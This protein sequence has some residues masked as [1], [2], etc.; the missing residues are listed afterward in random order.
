MVYHVETKLQ[1]TKSEIRNNI[2][3]LRRR[4]ISLWLKMAQKL[5]TKKFCCVFVIKILVIFRL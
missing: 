2:E 3:I 5:E 1:N 4:R